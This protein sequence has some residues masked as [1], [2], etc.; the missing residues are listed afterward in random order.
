MD[1]SGGDRGDR[2]LTLVELLIAVAIIGILSAIMIPGYISGQPMR[3]L[4]SAGR[5][6]FSTFHL[7]R[8]EA[9]AKYRAHRVLFDISNREF[10]LERA[11]ANCI[12]ACSCTT[13]NPVLETTHQLPGGVA[14][15]SVNG[16]TSGTASHAYN[17]NGTA[18]DLT[19][20]C[21]NGNTASVILTNSRGDRYEVTVSVLGN[22]RMQKL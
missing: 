14:F 20:A 1:T 7:A 17:V 16:V 11:E 6:V 4:K 5:D 15:E 9:A 19:A 3:K 18:Q 12:Q 21:P 8:S 13:W 2:G 10:R 22:I